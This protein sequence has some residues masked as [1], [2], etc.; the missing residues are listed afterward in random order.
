[1]SRFTIRYYFE[2][3]AVTCLWG[4]DDV[5]REQFG[6]NINPEDLPL[7]EQTKDDIRAM[8]VRWQE[9]LDWDA[10]ADPSP[11]SEDDFAMFF[12]DS[13]SLFQQ[14]RAELDDEFELINVMSNFYKPV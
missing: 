3:M 5:T 14:I 2:Y 7:S 10:P 8:S 11:W 1:M 6:V 12:K 9:S 4:A 13:E